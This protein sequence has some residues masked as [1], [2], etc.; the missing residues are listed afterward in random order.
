[1]GHFESDRD[2]SIPIPSSFFE[3][4]LARIRDLAAIKVLL[5]VYLHLSDLDPGA[6]FISED[7]IFADRQL[8]NGVRLTGSNRDPIEEIRHGVDVLA[9][10]DAIVRIVVEEDG[11][12]SYWLM[13]KSPQN[14]RLLY[15]F[16]N[17]SRAFPYRQTRTQAKARVAIERPN[18][19]RLFEQ[20]IGVV[21]P[22]I[23][24]QIIE[25][26]EIYP[27]GWIED[28]INEAVSL[29]RRSWRYIQRILERWS[30]EG[31]GDEAYRRNQ[32]ASGFVEREKY[33][34][35]KYSSLF[36]RGR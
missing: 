23:A 2:R 31:R 14:Q 6:P 27:A 22:L 12:E 4:H 30:T 26:I 7:A 33:L 18:V 9:A 19:F 24:D 13:P 8:V 35:G 3:Q 1:M 36:K 11:E 29:N 16:V 32:S 17:G 28:A 15:T 20:N 25:A 34:R 5:T 21:T 10:H